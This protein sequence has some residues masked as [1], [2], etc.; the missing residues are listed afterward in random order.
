MELKAL[1]QTGY[2]IQNN[3]ENGLK[4]QLNKPNTRKEKQTEKHLV[5][6]YLNLY[7][8]SFSQLL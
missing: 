7:K 5:K 8:L 1:G 2:R 3:C 4:T 6:L